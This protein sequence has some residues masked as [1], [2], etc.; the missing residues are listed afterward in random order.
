MTRK[1]IPIAM[2]IA[3]CLALTSVAY[4]GYDLTVEV[5]INE[6][7]ARGGLTDVSDSAD[8]TQ[9]IYCAT[10]SWG[11][12]HQLGVCAARDALGEFH[13]CRTDDPEQIRVIQSVS[14][15]SYVTFQWDTD[16]P[17]IC[18]YVSVTNGSQFM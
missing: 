7:Y 9:F 4:A 18:T 8:N 15:A 17:N 13:S 5:F 3:A 6:G 2:A 16:D 12:G 1:R 11:A 14:D 10:A